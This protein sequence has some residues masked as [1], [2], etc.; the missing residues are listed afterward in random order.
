[1]SNA[2]LLSNL[3]TAEFYFNSGIHEAAEFILSKILKQHPLNSKANELLAY[4]KGQQGHSNVAHSLLEIAC[5]DINCSPESHYYL[6][7]S[8]LKKQS[9]N[10]SILHFKLA[11]SKGGDFFEGLYNL[12]IAQASYGA[13]QDAL[14]SFSLALK[15]NNNHAELLNNIGRIQFELGYFRESLISFDA[16]INIFSNY[17]DAWFNKGNVFSHLKNH[18]EAIENFNKAIDINPNFAMAYLNKGLTLFS[19]N[20]NGEAL[21]CY[22]RASEINP[23]LSKCWS[24]IGLL[25]D[26]Q[27]N[28]ELALNYYERAINLDNLNAETYSNKALVHEKSKDF[29]QALFNIDIAIKLDPNSATY[30]L[31]KGLILYNKNNLVESVACYTRANILDPSLID[32]WYNKAIALSDIGDFTNSIYCYKKA[33][34]LNYNF[35]E[36]HFNLSFLYFNIFD[37]KSAWEEYQWRWQVKDYSSA[38]LITSK[39]KW[40]GNQVNNRLFIWSEQGIGDQVLFSSVFT[41]LSTYQQEIIISLETKLI[42]IFERSFPRFTFVNRLIPMSERDY[43]EHISITDLFSLFRTSISDFTPQFVPYLISNPTIRNKF[44]KIFDSENYTICGLSWM[45]SNRDIGSFKSIPFTVF[46]SFNSLIN[47]KFINLQDH[48]SKSE[49]DSLV[50]SN[51]NVFNIDGV[52]LLNDIDSLASAICACDIIVTCSNS[53]AHLAGALNK[54]TLLLVPYSKGKLWYWNLTVDGLSM[55][56]PSVR[57]FQQEYFGN[58]EAP[59]FEAFKFLELFDKKNI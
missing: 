49:S 47:F 31:N 50:S 18:S 36:A 12:G 35:A 40:N 27:K 17:A 23:N 33:I 39:P 10:Q 51:L 6:A 8:Y 43:D 44:R 7:S 38:P 1:M 3:K 9:F 24:A 41:I 13:F 30:Y 25:Y 16:A 55:L 4:I 21:D 26:K 58:W 45:S 15:L 29:E 20:R 14:D 22:I 57:I 46:N 42:P 11:I 32:A 5:N 54:P 56:Y 34:E 48:I 59:I 53:I 52:D 28:Y 37:F 2:K 19:I